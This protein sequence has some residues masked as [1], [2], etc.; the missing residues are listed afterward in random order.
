MS[1]PAVNS[2][3]GGSQA[4][5][6]LHIP[7]CKTK[8]LYCSFNSHAGREEEIAGYLAA[9]N[10]H[11][12]RL[13]GHPWCRSHSFFS[14]YIGGGTPTIC[15]PALLGQ[16]IRNCLTA[17]S[18][19][20]E[21]GNH[22]GVQSQYPVPAKLQA[23]REAGVNRLSIG[24]QS[25]SPAQLKSLGRSHTA[26]DAVLAFAMAREAGFTN[27]NLDLMYGLPGLTAEGWRQTLERP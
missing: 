11:I 4:A 6:Y 1:A 21:A 9:L 25:F 5:I 12:R 8:C 15:D 22:G 14:L 16:V 7:F 27:I 3:A 10:T 18:F 24:V 2:P 26:E 20:P 23:L 13:A 19:C 17:F